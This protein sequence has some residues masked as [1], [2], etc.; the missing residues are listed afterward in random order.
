VF[1]SGELIPHTFLAL[2]SCPVLDIASLQCNNPLLIEKT[3]GIC[4]AHQ[5]IQM[6]IL[7]CMNYLNPA[8]RDEHANVIVSWMTQTGQLRSISHK[9]LVNSS[10]GELQDCCFEQNAKSLNQSALNGISSNLKNSSS[11]LLV[12][13]MLS[14]YMEMEYRNTAR[15]RI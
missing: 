1:H 4:A 7:D 10:T 13:K 8:I 11:R 9:G 3:L 2:L 14:P 15:P 12:G 6:E 5:A